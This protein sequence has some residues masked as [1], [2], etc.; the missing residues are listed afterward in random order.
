[1][2]CRLRGNLC[3]PDYTRIASSRFDNST[4][5]PTK[6]PSGHHL[7]PQIT[8]IR[9]GFVVLRDDLAHPFVNGN[10]L[11]KLDALWPPLTREA[12]A[13]VTCGGAQSAHLVAVAALCAASEFVGAHLLVRGEQPAV[14][15]GNLL[16]THALAG[17]VRYVPRAEYADRTSM[18][19][20]HAA[21]T[22]EALGLEPSQVH[23]LPE[24]GAEPLALLGAA[25]L[26]A[27]LAAREPFRS[28]PRVEIVLDCGTGA[29]A[30]GLALGI[31]LRGLPAWRVRGVE[32]GGP[33]GAA[34]ATAAALLRRA[35]EELD[36]DPEHA[37][38]AISSIDWEPR[39]RPRK[40][41]RMLPG[42]A[43]AVRAVA[44]AHGVVLDPLWTLA[45]WEAAEAQ[46]S[47]GTLTALLHT[48]G[49]LALTA[50]AQRWPD[51]FAQEMSQK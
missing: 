28:A 25:R 50:A 46:Q 27:W 30:A 24:G 2:A 45:A 39:R 1:M 20:R 16:F 18:L 15:T 36:F 38:R 23:I 4:L 7:H 48:G 31:A 40:F 49:P 21:R 26:V 13:V 14:L 6:Y 43:A 41:G 32:V 33:P 19:E 42:D 9:P 35:A 10:K 12:R 47:P 5:L 44:S 11:R 29:T 8:T 17:S 37:Q 3:N 22:C 34:P 51:L